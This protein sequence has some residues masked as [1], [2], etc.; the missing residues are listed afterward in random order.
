MVNFEDLYVG[1]TIKFVDDMGSMYPNASYL[2]VKVM[3]EMD[4]KTAVVSSIDINN[5]TFGIIGYEHPGII[6][7]DKDVDYIIEESAKEVDDK[8]IKS[9]F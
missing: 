4:G 2:L 9:L 8:S 5:K 7:L 6:W 1:A 3:R